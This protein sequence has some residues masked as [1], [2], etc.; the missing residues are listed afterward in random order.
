MSEHYTVVHSPEVNPD[1]P[2]AL[3]LDGEVIDLFTTE[4]EAADLAA[5][6]NAGTP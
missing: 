4:A 6:Y 2:W 5:E 1:V 3:V